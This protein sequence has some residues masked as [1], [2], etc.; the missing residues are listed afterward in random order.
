M[1]VS[2]IQSVQPIPSVHP[3]QNTWPAAAAQSAASVHAPGSSAFS[4][5]AQ[6]ISVSLAST[7]DT[8]GV[9][10]RVRTSR[11]GFLPDSPDGTTI[12]ANGTDGANGSAGSA[13]SS[14]PH[15]WTI[16]HAPSKKVQDPPPKP[17]YKVLLEHLKSIWLASAGAVHLQNPAVDQAKTANAN[18]SATPGGISDTALSSSSTGVTPVGQVSPSGKVSLPHN[19]RPQSYLPS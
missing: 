1:Q 10:G 4:S 11:A 7:D 8:Y 17:L 15:D 19:H 9:D 16:H 12:G 13:G 2:S 6:P 14:T 3:V 5:D 18:V